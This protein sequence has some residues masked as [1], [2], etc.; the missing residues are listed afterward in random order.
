MYKIIKL[1]AK[2]MKTVSAEGERHYFREY[3]KA[4]HKPAA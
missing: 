1:S 3:G 4:F 2:M